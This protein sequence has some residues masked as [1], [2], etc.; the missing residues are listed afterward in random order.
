[1]KAWYLKELK[2]DCRTGIKMTTMQHNKTLVIVRQFLDELN[3]ERVGEPSDDTET[4]TIKRLD[5]Q[6]L[7]INYRQLKH[8]RNQYMLE[9]MN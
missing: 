9:K 7:S 4:S 3:P 2:H 8:A 6:E 5:W 1:M